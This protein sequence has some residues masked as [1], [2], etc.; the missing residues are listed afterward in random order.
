ML[1]LAGGSCV[2]TQRARRV[3]RL[4]ND[5]LPTNIQVP[6]HHSFAQPVKSYSDGWLLVA[7][8]DEKVGLGAVARIR[9]NSFSLLGEQGQPVGVG[10]F[11]AASRCVSLSF[12]LCLWSGDFVCA[13]SGPR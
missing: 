6:S 1:I 10:L 3:V 12:S 13:A 5:I 8:M 2:Q 9:A 11:L 4:A 7:Q